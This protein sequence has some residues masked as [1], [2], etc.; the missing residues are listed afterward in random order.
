MK[1]HISSRIRVDDAVL[2]AICLKTG[3]LNLVTE[4]G[5]PAHTIKIKAI[6]YCD[7]LIEANEA[8]Q[9]TSQLSVLN[10]NCDQS[11]RGFRHF[12][13]S[14]V[15]LND[16]T[17]AV[18]A[19]NLLSV[20]DKY[21]LEM[22]SLPIDE[23]YTKMK[24]LKSDLSKESAQQDIAA[25]PSCSLFVE[26]F[27]AEL[28]AYENFRNEYSAVVTAA[29][30]KATASEVKDDFMVFFNTDYSDFMVYNEKYS[31]PIYHEITES[32]I[33]EIKRIEEAIKRR[34]TAAEKRKAKE[35]ENETQEPTQPVEGG[36]SDENNS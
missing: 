28:E 20:F 12:I 35:E 4:E 1:L 26:K 27:Y 23:Q 14:F 13:L 11:L 15:E 21:G 34:K 3:M 36:E 7:K 19:R 29:R 22:L 31:E 2:L 16:P 5:T 10:R 6:E 9:M 18:S 25:I 32:L 33:T 30:G 17:N 8:D 24:G